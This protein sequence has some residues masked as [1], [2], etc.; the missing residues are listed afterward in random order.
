[1][2]RSWAEPRRTRIA[3]AVSNAGFA[4]HFPD[5]ADF[6]GGYGKDMDEAWVFAQSP[7]IL[8]GQQGPL[9][10]PHLLDPHQMGCES[11]PLGEA[12]MTKSGL[13]GP[14]QNDRPISTAGIRG[15]L[16]KHG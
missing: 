5:R 12:R 7:Q 14:F 15:T 13:F 4:E 9:L 1:M 6:L 2:S 10:T 11:P 3:R 16:F 8:Q